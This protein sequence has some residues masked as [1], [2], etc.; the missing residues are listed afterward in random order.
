MKTLTVKKASKIA[1]KMHPKFPL[2]PVCYEFEDSYVFTFLVHRIVPVKVF[3]K[4]I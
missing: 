4:I 2:C 1:Q 3:K